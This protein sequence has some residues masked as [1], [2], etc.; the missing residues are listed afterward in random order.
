MATPIDISQLD[1][2]VRRA[3]DQLFQYLG[4]LRELVFAGLGSPENVVTATRAI[5]IRLDGGAGTT[6]YVKESGAATNTGW[7]GK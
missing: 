3:F 5:Y 1:D 2:E 6:L 7:V 4:P